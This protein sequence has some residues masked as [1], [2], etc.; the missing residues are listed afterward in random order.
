[1]GWDSSSS[2]AVSTVRLLTMCYEFAVL[3]LDLLSLDQDRRGLRL[4]SIGRLLRQEA[5]GPGDEDT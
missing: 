5:D 4:R 2:V 1:M 3:S